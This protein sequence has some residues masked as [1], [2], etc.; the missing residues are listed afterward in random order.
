MVIFCTRCWAPNPPEAKTC[1]HCGAPLE[2]TKGEFVEKLISALRH[3]EPGTVQLA[4]WILG[5]QEEARAVPALIELLKRSVE[6]GALEAA[7]EALGKIGDAS[8]VDVLATS[9]HQ[10]PLRVRLRVAE[11]LKHIGGP[12]AKEALSAMLEDR[13]GSVKAAAQAA[14]E[15]SEE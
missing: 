6:P 8:A 14:L 5:E 13:S 2:P 1:L 10:W 4:A 7:V 15:L 11:T 12:R 3:P 9:G